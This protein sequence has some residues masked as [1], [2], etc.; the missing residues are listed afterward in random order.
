MK[1]LYMH[2]Y[3]TTRDMPGGTRSYE[4]AVRLARAGHEVHVLTSDRRPGAPGGWR[5]EDVDGVTVHW[6]GVPYDNRMGFARRILAFFEFALKALARAVRV[7]GD[8]VLATSTPLT[9]AIPGALAA[10]RL[11]VPMVLEVRDLWPELPIAVGALRDP[12]SRSAARWLERFAYRNAHRGIALSPGMKAGMVAGGMDAGQVSVIPN[13]C[14]IDLFDVPA[15]RG[16]EFRARREWLGERPLVVYAG[17]LGLING[18]EYMALIAREAAAIDPEV[19][20]LV[21]GTGAR[22]TAVREAAREAGVLGRSFFMEPP[23]AK[24]E[25]PDLLSAADVTTSFFVDLAVMWA[26]S[27]NK[28]FDGLASGTPVAINYRGWQAEMLE[29]TG[30]GL[31]LPPDDPKSAAKALCSFL[32]DLSRVEDAGAAA[33]SLA[34][35]SFD[36]EKLAAKMTEVLEEALDAWER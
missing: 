8:L 13:G 6:V 18:V 21:C 9:I 20:F 30:A 32:A 1:L 33:L 15:S 28:F 12:L 27:A 14:D 25:V 11:R 22:E 23:V 17:T 7:G 31:V 29:S 26:N 4:M 16:E 35:E 2:Q 5:V 24:G 19:R 34:R 10:R 3:F 36:R